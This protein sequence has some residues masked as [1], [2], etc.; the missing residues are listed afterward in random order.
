MHEARDINLTRIVN[1]EDRDM[2]TKDLQHRVQNY[3]LERKHKGKKTKKAART[4][5]PDVIKKSTA[6]DRRSLFVFDNG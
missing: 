6:L 1:H 5:E 3:A 4:T 2:T